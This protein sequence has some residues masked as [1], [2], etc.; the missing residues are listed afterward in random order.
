MIKAWIRSQYNAPIFIAPSTPV[1]H[2]SRKATVSTVDAGTEGAKHL[3]CRLSSARFVLSP[4]NS[5]GDDR[6]ASPGW[7]APVPSKSLNGRHGLEIETTD[8][9]ETRSRNGN[10]Q[11]TITAVSLGACQRL[12]PDSE[13]R[14]WPR[15]YVEGFNPL[16][17][18]GDK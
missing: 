16:F 8:H 17:N 15:P 4:R 1:C 5:D 10:K 14:N 2:G 12:S 6:A 11:R 13:P 7:G 9:F 18:V 3:T